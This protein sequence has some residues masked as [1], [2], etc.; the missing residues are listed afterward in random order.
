LR[1]NCRP[2]AEIDGH[3]AEKAGLRGVK[4][5]EFLELLL[6][7]GQLARIERINSHDGLHGSSSHRALR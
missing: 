4:P 6:A 3:A 2:L 1:T 7:R 5:V